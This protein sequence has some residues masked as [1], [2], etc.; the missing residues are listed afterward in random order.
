MRKS[1]RITSLVFAGLLAA[2]AAG[3]T[4]VERVV[5]VVGDRAIL[6]SDL[7]DRAK[8]FL[9]R[10]HQE[11]PAGAQRSA[12]VSQTYKTLLERM[13]DEE[14]EQRAANRSNI[15]V[16]AREVDE[17]VSRI[18][19]QNGLTIDQLIVEATRSGLTETQYRSEVRRQVLEAK[20]LNLRLQ[21]RIRVTEEDLRSAYR[22]IVLEE[23]RKQ[24]YRA[25]WI[26]IDAPQAAP[27]EELTRRHAL[28]E[29]LGE[30][31]R[32]G[33]DFAALARQHSDDAATREAGGM[34]GRLRPGQLHPTLDRLVLGLELGEVS[35][36]V[37]VG[38]AVF[39]I[40]LLER[41]ESELPSFEESRPE[42]GE[43][44]YLEKMAKAR[45]HWLDSLRRQT[46]VD[47]RL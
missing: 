29:S 46:H 45:R 4:V 43:R 37:R 47:V 38:E 10:I 8:P 5:A 30:R 42:L 44:V 20:L 32:E 3:A 16:S 9:I 11:V 23:R 1:A 14:L 35:T 22:K 21:G 24:P 7:R 40:K 6:L 41:D 33:A 13:V 34:L 27:R 2:T 28:A 36:P 19:A 25:A 39:V 18:A 12:A 17:A 15:A 31:A 26:R